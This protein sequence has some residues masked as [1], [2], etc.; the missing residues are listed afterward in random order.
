M[1]LI[2]EQV[3]TLLVESKIDSNTKQY[4]IEGIFMQ[5]NIQN[6]NGRIYPLEI[7]EREV[8]LYN[9]NFIS[10][11][12]AF[13]ECDHPEE[14]NIALERV[15]HRIVELYRDGNNFIGKAKIMDTP[16]GRILKTFIDEGAQLGVSSRGV[17]SLQENAQGVQV[18]Q[19]DFH[20]CTIDAVSDPSSPN[21][22]VRGIMEG[23][24][25]VFENG[26]LTERKAEQIKK[27]VHR[28]PAKQVEAYLLKE[29]KNLL[30]KL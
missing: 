22:F 18:V 13:G 16:R 29:F 15:S 26:I 23:K 7:L 6:R 4:F 12:R 2:T 24:E 1:R 27:T 8:S 9:K 30:S 17:G 3:D 5:A 20:L 10:K 28:L 11:N 21:A 19:E 25:W 14:L